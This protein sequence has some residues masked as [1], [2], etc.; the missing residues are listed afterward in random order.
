MSQ[1]GV[2]GPLLL[3]FVSDHVEVLFDLDR[4]ARSMAAPGGLQMVRA[5]TVETHSHFVR[6]I[7]GLINGRMD[8]LP[9]QS[10]LVLEPNTDDRPENGCLAGRSALSSA[11]T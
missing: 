4:E 1:P 9:P 6:T 7:R 2:E 3:G 8:A 10:L 5:S 11:S